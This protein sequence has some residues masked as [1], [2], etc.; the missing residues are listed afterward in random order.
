MKKAQQRPESLYNLTGQTRYIDDAPIPASTLH[1]VPV[2]SRSAK[3]RNLKIDPKAALAV[4]ASVR[5][6]VASDVPGENQL[7]LAL[8]DDPLIAGGEWHFKGQ[9]VALVLAKDRRT[10]RKAAA[11]VGVSGED[12]PPVTDPREAF[13]RGDLIL[14][15]MVHVEG[16]L[17]AA[18]RSAK[19]V[20][21]GRCES[22][23]QEHVYLETQSAL[24]YPEEGGRMK[25]LS[26]TQSPTHT[27][28]AVARVLGVPYSF[29]EVETGR[30]GGGF[31]GKED[32]A[33][34]WAALAAVGAALTGKPVKLVLSRPDDMRMT[35][36]RHPYSTDFRLALG[37]DGK[38]LGYEATYYQN[39][40]ATTDLSPAILSRTLFHATGAYRIPAVKATGYMCRTNLPSFTAYRGFGAPQAFFAVES[41]ISRAAELSGIPAAE[42]Q[43]KNLFREGDLTHYRMPLEDCRAERA[44]EELEKTAKL[45]K[46][47]KEIDD[48]NRSNRLRKRGLAVQSDCFG[49]SF[50]KLMLNQ[51][52]ALVHAFTDGSVSVSTGAIEMGQGV[53]RKILVTA[54]RTLGIGEDRVR[55]EKTS[56]ATVANTSPTAAS[57]GSDINAAAAQ[58]ACDEL[59][60]RLLHFAAGLPRF[61]NGEAPSAVPAI[62]ERLELRD[63]LVHLDGRKTDLS[64][65]ELVVKAH[66]A[67]I[68][69]SA[70][71]F[72]ATPGL[73]LDMATAKGSPF[74][75]HVY[76]AAAVVVELDVLRGALRVERVHIVHDGGASIDPLIDRGQ[77]EGG[78]AQALGWVLLEELRFGKDGSLLT[79][80]LSTYKLPDLR[81]LDFPLEIRHLK[82]AANS[83]AVLGS[84]AVG[85]PPFIYGLAAYFAALEAL[86]AA[87]PG[88]GFYDLPLTG[89]K[90][91]AYLTGRAPC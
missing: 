40:G 81:F 71:A 31:G 4:D 89:E 86:K 24:V 75:Y 41:A 34:Q 6:L 82:D 56:T 57:T 37:A 49:I 72:Y 78:L 68:D 22:G 8:P 10:A 26:S 16:D 48:F 45:A 50:T 36:K 55:V 17:D 59:R 88:T 23:G 32:Q 42:I 66:E 63:A 51:G 85:E 46:L 5:V 19:W 33:S 58:L 80:T 1:A 47:R 3:G 77:I 11:R 27:Q 20:V 39:S 13:K 62:A 53:N 70:H 90:A 60:R 28:R 65:N 44:W 30:I 84:K 35:G 83:K 15:P 21:E 76:G 54:A 87:R 79:D 29:V 74:A 12:L 52:G 73:T 69:L 61:L 2:G 18:F 38:I 14:K 7:G 67:R 43:R 91:M 9:V 25:V 64:W